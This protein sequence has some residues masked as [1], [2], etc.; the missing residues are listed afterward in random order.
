MICE[1]IH[2]FYHV[3]MCVENT[4]EHEQKHT[5]IFSGAALVLQQAV[6]ILAVY[7][8]TATGSKAFPGCLF[9]EVDRLFLWNLSEGTKRTISTAATAK[10][11][12]YARQ[13]PRRL[14]V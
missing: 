2:L 11:L 8:K 4:K 1:C 5:Y 13:G 6:H 10:C 3:L 9:P 14:C 12:D 7:T